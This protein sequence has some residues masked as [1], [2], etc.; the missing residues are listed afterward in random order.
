[1]PLSSIFFLALLFI[2]IVTIITVLVRTATFPLE[3]E[4][5]PPVN[6]PQ[7]DGESVAQRLGLAIQ[8][9]TISS[10]HIKEID[11]TPFWGLHQLMH[12]LY[13]MID[14]KLERETINEYALLYTWKGSNPQ[15]DPVCFMAHQDVV[16]A[17]ENEANAWKYPPF[18]GTVAEGYVWG[19]GAIDCKGVLVG[20]LE[21]VNNLL[22]EGYQP[23]RTI[24]LAFGFDE[25]NMGVNGAAAISQTLQKRGIKLSFVLD[26]GGAITTDQIKEVDQPVAAI[27]VSEKGFQTLRLKAKTASGHASMPPEHTAIG[28]LALA[29]ANLEANPFPQ[30]LE[31]VQ[32]MLSHLGSALPFLQRMALANTWLFGGLL[33]KKLAGHPTMN[34]LTRTTLAPTI[35]KG[36][37]TSNVLPAE[38][39][40][41]INLRIMA[42]E[43]REEVFQRVHEMVGDDV[44]S[45]LPAEGETLKED[46]GWNPSPVSDVESA[47]FAL[48]ANL[49]MAA[50]PSTLVMP[51]MFTGAT[52]ARYYGP[53]CKNTYRF[54]PFVLSSEELAT[55]HGVNE[56]LSVANCAKAV[57]FYM[58]LMRAVSSIT[59]EEEAS[60]GESDEEDEDVAEKPLKHPRSSKIA[61]PE[62]SPVTQMNA[63]LPVKN[64]KQPPAQH[65]AYPKEPLEAPQAQPT[66]EQ[67]QEKETLASELRPVKQTPKQHSTDFEALPEDDEPLVVKPLKKS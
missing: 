8:L 60:F 49:I 36:G 61:D 25:E 9:K 55:T 46:H 13:P 41:M 62:Q 4:E 17:E 6:L 11:P 1:M 66:A 48:L 40:T 18:S 12:T 64:L 29:I 24:Y 16:P 32:F 67:A 56:R 47:Q 53:I 52:D 5:V 45:V 10:T 42:G 38:A 14:E 22:R 51:I 65:I 19:R 39:E 23:L 7:V 15:L 31:V 57:G 54:A 27:G 35:I 63:H 21:S 28:S 2:L 33:R 58:E 34:A 37:Q 43:T 3:T 20:I 44:V 59:S 50:Y 30:R 26:E